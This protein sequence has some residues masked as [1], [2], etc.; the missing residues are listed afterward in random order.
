ME[1][2]NIPLETPPSLSLSGGCAVT[3]RDLGVVGGVVLDDPVHLGDVQSSGGHVRAQQDPRVRVAELK[4]GGGALGLLLLPLQTRE[5][6]GTVTLA[7]HAH[8][9]TV[10][11]LFSHH[12]LLNG[13]HSHPSNLAHTLSLSYSILLTHFLTLTF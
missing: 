5:R 11:H 8:T 13:T 6:S 9:P 3:G 4:E 10:T 1:K 2:A 12:F 7:L